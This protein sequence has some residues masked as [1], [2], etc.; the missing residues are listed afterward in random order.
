M[1]RVEIPKDINSYKAEFALGFTTRQLISLIIVLVLAVPTFL[2]FGKIIGTSNTIYIVVFEALL[3]MLIGFCEIDGKTFEDYLKIIIN[4]YTT[5]SQRKYVY[6]SKN[7]NLH[8]EIKEIIFQAE[9]EERKRYL[10]DLKI[11][12]KLEA[13]QAKKDKKIKNKSERKVKNAEQ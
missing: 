3:P 11:K 9:C 12:H 1:I 8:R 5:P 7:D 6:V 13:K 10:K 2:I 4:Y